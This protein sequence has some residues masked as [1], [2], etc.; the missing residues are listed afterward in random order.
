MLQRPSSSPGPLQ[1]RE[2]PGHLREPI[3]GLS[4]APPTW[5]AQ[6]EPKGNRSPPAH[7]GPF[8]PWAD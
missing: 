3:E 1:S 8:R 2:Q 5:V 7:P 4:Q 6:Q